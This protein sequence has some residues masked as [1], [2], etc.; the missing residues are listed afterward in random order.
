MAEVFLKLFLLAPKL[1]LHL[2][3]GSAERAQV[4][5]VGILNSFNSLYEATQK[6]SAASQLKTDAQQTQQVAERVS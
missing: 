6:L 5:L 4:L 1:L 2:K 3:L